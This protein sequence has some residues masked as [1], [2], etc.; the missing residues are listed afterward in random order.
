M[1][2]TIIS[3]CWAVAI[4]FCGI[5]STAESQEKLINNFSTMKV[6]SLLSFSGG[7][8]QWCGY[9]RE[10]AELALNDIKLVN[11]LNSKNSEPVLDFKIIF[12]DDHSIDKKSAVGA[13]SKLINMQQVDVLTT[14]TASTAPVLIP[15]ANKNKIPLIVG[16]Y[17]SNVAKGGG[18]VFGAFVNYDMLPREIA[19]FLVIKR[20][21]KKVGLLT[22]EDD[23]S[24][25]FVT[26]FKEEVTK[27][28]EILVFEDTVLPTEKDLKPQIIKLKTQGVEAVL[29]PLY[30]SSLYTFLRQIKELGYQGLIHVGDGMFEDDIKVVGEAAEGVFSSQIWLDSK[31]FLDKYKMKYKNANP[32]Q[33]GLVASGYDITKH[34]YEVGF[35]LLSKN[36]SISKENILK[37]LRSF[38]SKGYLGNLMM[39]KPPVGTG[40][41]LMIVKSGRYQLAE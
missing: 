41:K 16:A 27:L 26:A 6:G 4:C 19:N 5:N 23:W 13:A 22:A 21:V 34:L 8:E 24:Q 28:G 14:W 20:G 29:S 25:S 7:L 39:G 40:E 9:I 11:D 30:G 10:G 31:D 32:L 1:K 2:K 3:A 18:H 35:S 33:L 12:E 17:D 15:I 38:E 37:E 36:Q